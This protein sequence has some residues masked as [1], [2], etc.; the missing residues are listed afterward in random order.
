MK[1]SEAVLIVVLVLCVFGLV[2]T[3]LGIME[4]MLAR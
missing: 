3:L 2:L 4:N 1:T